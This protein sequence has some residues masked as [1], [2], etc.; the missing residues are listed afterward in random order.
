M[1]IHNNSSI[2]NKVTSVL[3][4]AVDIF[5]DIPAPERYKKHIFAILFLKFV[6]DMQQNTE[7]ETNHLKG[8]SEELALPTGADFYSLYEQRNEEN[9]GE[10]IDDALSQIE[11]K[12][13][14][15]L[16]GLF[17]NISFASDKVFENTNESNKRLKKL[18]ETLGDPHFIFSSEQLTGKEVF[19]LLLERFALAESKR[20]GEYYS[21]QG[22]INL[23]M[24]IANPAEGIQIYDPAMGTGGMLIAANNW[25]RKADNKQ[26]ANVSLYGQ[27]ISEDAVFLARMNFLFNEIYTANLAYG[28]TLLSPQHLEEGKT[29]RFD[30]VFSNPPF[31][32]RLREHQVTQLEK[33]QYNRFNYGIPNRIADLAFLQHIIASLNETGKAVVAVP[34]GVLFRSGQ[35]G[36]IRKRIIEEDLVEAVISLAPALLTN[37]TIPINLLIIN[38]AKRDSLKG[39]IL[40][41]NASTEYERADR[42]INTITQEQAVKIAS[43]Y[44]SHKEVQSFSHIAELDDIRQQEFNLLPL[45]YID[46]IDVSNFLGGNVEWLSISK[47]ANIMLGTHGRQD[48]EMQGEIPV[49]KAANI[50]NS[51]LQEAELDLTSLPKDTSR[52]LFAKKGDI[53]I[54]RI[55]SKEF[56]LFYIEEELDGVLVHQSLFVIRVAKPYH[57]LRKYII[58]FFRSEKGQEILTQ[59]IINMGAALSLRISDLRRMKLPVPCNRVLELL[60]TLHLVE[61]KFSERLERAK[62]IR[63][64]LFNLDDPQKFNSQLETLTTNAHVLSSSLVQSDTLEYQVRNF[65][66]FPIAFAYRGISSIH[67]I[68]E[69]Y[70]EQLRVA[71]NLLAFLANIGIALC[72]CCGVLAL[73]ENK[74]LTA[75]SLYSFFGGGISPGDWQ[76]MAYSAGY[77]LRNVDDYSLVKS[78]SSLWFKGSGAKASDFTKSTKRLA[79]LKNDYKHDR[80]PKISIEFEEASTEVQSLLDLCYEELSFLVKYPMRSIETLDI[81]W[82]SNEALFDT[83]EYV[84]DHPALPK[85]QVVYPKP[86]P[87]KKLYLELTK[88]IWANLYPFISVQVCPSCKTRETYF[89]DRWDSTGNKVTLKSFERSHTHES[90]ADAQIVAD[91]LQKWIDDNLKDQ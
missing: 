56:N 44:Q 10:I 87:K 86:L 6:S 8:I 58:E 43:V 9:L 82:H 7:K 45:R 69:K 24:A 21:P 76:S 50:R 12:N 20:G 4:K 77:L 71:E 85:K 41:I 35:E 59:N 34:S 61:E 28:D 40:F 31:G 51:R 67:E 55:A 36:E 5:H 72:H 39:K 88:D 53:L 33:D 25:I 1:T 74:T 23:I 32:L 54:S 70:R 65:Y 80:G 57:Y 16:K 3:W 60:G 79:V 42:R 63:T 17:Q 15:K 49:I 89:V 13:P 68:S 84:G 47:I 83:L 48:A 14:K 91:D 75:P 38:K 64:D 19:A 2:A 90:D 27:D 22:I 11:R 46:S 78:F 26:P 37:T 29:Q 52:V 66:P 62:N 81:D 18:L 30:L 73:D